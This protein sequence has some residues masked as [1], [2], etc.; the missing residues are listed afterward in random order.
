MSLLHRL[1]MFADAVFAI[2]ITILAIELRPPHGA[3]GGLSAALLA[4]WPKLLS[5]ALSF[6]VIAAVWLNHVRIARLLSG[7][8]RA[9]TWMTLALLAGIAFLPFPTAVLGEAGAE[10]AA[11]VFYAGSVAAV[12]CLQGALWLLVRRRASLRRPDAPESL[13]RTGI[14]RSFATAAVFAVSVPVAMVLPLAGMLL[15][16]LTLPVLALIGRLPLTEPES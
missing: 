1:V 3:S 6:V 12:A 5:F 9:L 7:A 15:W 10:P 11:V 4:M 13:L 16:A 8:D 2:A 14:R